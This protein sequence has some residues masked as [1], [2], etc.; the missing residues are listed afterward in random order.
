MQKAGDVT[1]LLKDIRGISHQ[2]ETNTSVYNALDEAKR[3]YYTY[4]Q[5][6]DET[7]AKHLSNFKSIVQVIEHFG[8][9]IFQDD[10]LL[11]HKMTAILRTVGSQ[12]HPMNMERELGIR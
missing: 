2:L 5:G 11:Q 1:T 6:D 7:N 4:C 8:G 10:A 12:S 9:N 3:R